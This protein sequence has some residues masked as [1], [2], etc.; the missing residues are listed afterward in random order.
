[1]EPFELLHE[2]WSLYRK[3]LWSL[4][5]YSAWM[6]LPVGALFLLTFA[7]DHWLVFV[8]AMLCTL[9]EIYLGL[10][11]TVAVARSVTRFSQKQEVNPTAISHESLLRIPSL[12]R[13]AMLQ[14]LVV[15]GGLLLFVIPGIV[16]TVWYAFAQLA[17]V[18]DEKRPIEA[19]TFSKL[20][21]KGRFWAVA[22]RLT[23]VPIVIALIY[24]T[25]MGLL[26][27][28]F[29]TYTGADPEFLLG[30]EGP[31]WVPLM[32]AIVQVFLIPFLLT[33]SVLLFQDLKKHPVEPLDKGCDV[34]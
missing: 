14:A 8:V 5:G 17:T 18:L 10:W 31:S 16:F 6:L 11:M 28:A 20:L 2:S 26:V 33:Y 34:A 9:V 27:T 12:L 3:H 22:W 7:P 4:V 23:S 13:T 19:L 24:A 30:T 25:V 1:M 21:V 15:I 29:S 32:D